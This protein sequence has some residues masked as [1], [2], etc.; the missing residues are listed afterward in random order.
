MKKVIVLLSFVCAVLLGNEFKIAAK[1]YEAG[2]Y[3]KAFKHT[4]IACDNG[5]Y[6][7]C[8]FLGALYYN[9]QGVRQN[10]KEAFKYYKLACDN[11]EYQSCYNLGVLYAN[12]QGVRQNY[13]MTKE[14]FGKACDLG[15]QKGCDAFADL[16][17]KGY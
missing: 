8:G 5:N 11:G 9:G 15:D 1:A 2:D 7:G 13:S 14:Y 3:Q 6:K 4:K 12:G 17:Q 16:N 10:Y